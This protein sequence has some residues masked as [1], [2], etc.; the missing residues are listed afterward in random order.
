MWLSSKHAFPGFACSLI[1]PAARKGRARLGRVRPGML[2]PRLRERSVVVEH[3]D[4]LR[5]GGEVRRASLRHTFD[6]SS[7]GIL[8]RRI[9]SRRQW[10]R[11][12]SG[13]NPRG[14]TGG[15]TQCQDCQLGSLHLRFLRLS[16]SSH[17]HC[18]VPRSST[19]TWSYSS[20]RM[21]PI[22]G[23]S[24]SRMTNRLMPMITVNPRMWIQL[25]YLPSAMP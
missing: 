25:R 17:D 11:R 14:K 12:L 5:R 23:Y 13:S 6:K 8:R 3:G 7:N 9:V 19:S 2:I 18:I 24:I 20:R 22:R 21:K 15:A 4:A 10:I 1:S 16:C